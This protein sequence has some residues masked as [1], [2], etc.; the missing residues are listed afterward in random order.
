MGQHNNNNKIASVVTLF[1]VLV[2]SL[3]HHLSYADPVS[4]MHARINATIPGMPVTGVYF[5][6]RNDSDTVL[7]LTSVTSKVSNHIEIHEHV[8]TNGLMKMQEVSE[9]INIAS[10]DTVHFEPGGYHLMVMNLQKPIKEGE[11]V[12]LTLHFSDGTSQLIRAKG[13]KP[14]QSHPKHSHSGH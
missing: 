2:T 6:L 4:V 11:F 12:E 14:G 7:S 5:D 13:S 3:Y 8:M 1:I 9:G 10:R